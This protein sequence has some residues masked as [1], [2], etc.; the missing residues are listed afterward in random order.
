[1]RR[2]GATGVVVPAFARGLTDFAVGA[3]G[4]VAGM[5]MMHSEM[6]MSSPFVT[7]GK[8][9]KGEWEVGGYVGENMEDVFIEGL[10]GPMM[11]V[12]QSSISKTID[13]GVEFTA[14]KIENWRATTKK[15]LADKKFHAQVEAMTDEALE[16]EKG[17]A[18]SY[19]GAAKVI[20]EVQ[21]S[22]HG[23]TG[24]VDLGNGKQHEFHTAKD[25]ESLQQLFVDRFGDG[26]IDDAQ[27]K[28]LEKFFAL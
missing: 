25:N 19:R 28:F 22:D 9:K 6:G 17:T 3:S 20:G 12:T 26:A 14:E 23:T 7:F 27:V 11:D 13:T 2:M 8:N 18:S 1:M 4:E 15:D 21:E 5:K 24:I 10:A 16:T